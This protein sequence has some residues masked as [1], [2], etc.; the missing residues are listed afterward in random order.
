MQDLIADI[1]EGALLGD[2]WSSILGRIGDTCGTMGALLF[3]VSD[4]GVRWA[5]SGRAAELYED[6]VRLGWQNSPHNE[7]VH[8]LVAARHN[9][10]VI[11]VERHSADYIANNRM[12]QEFLIPRGAVAAAATH[13]IGAEGDGVILSVEGFSGLAPAQEQLPFLDG[14]R[15]HLARAAMVASRLQLERARA[16]TTALKAI[17]VAAAVITLKGTL[18]AANDLFEPMI[19]RLVHD[20][21]MG[22]RL[23]NPEA[24]SL[25]RDALE[26][27]RISLSHARSIPLP[28][29]GDEPARILHLVPIAGDARDL[30]SGPCVMMVVT[31]GSRAG[32]VQAQLL[33]TLFDLTPTEAR[34]ARDLAA[35]KSAADVA[36]ETGKSVGT[37]RVQ[38]KS[39]LAK[40]GLGSQ[41]A[42]VA[43]LKDL[44][45]GP[46]A[47]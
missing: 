33:E 35:S 37:V 5:G 47:G 24:N 39:I 46:G 19:G 17:G 20:G 10:F 12:Y 15:P 36:Q 44:A 16:M 29:S 31:G 14:L 43:L 26:R 18:R 42:L 13:V 23:D 27:M 11:D 8:E 30:F 1:Y 3:A 34:I 22:L 21:P 40:T 28:A 6:A 32:S 41:K 7:R 45:I 4:N 38:I 25:M 9:G 2:R